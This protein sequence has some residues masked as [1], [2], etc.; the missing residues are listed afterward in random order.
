MKQAGNSANGAELI[1]LMLGRLSLG[2]R[3]PF[4]QPD[5]GVLKALGATGAAWRSTYFE[6]AP[7]LAPAPCFSAK[8]TVGR[9][10]RIGWP[11]LA[12]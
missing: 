3:Q 8:I 11:K 7:G 5:G 9:A 4:G 12:N 2:G 1:R 6:L 10:G